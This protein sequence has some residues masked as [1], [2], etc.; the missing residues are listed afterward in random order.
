MDYITASSRKKLRRGL[1]MYSNTGVA[2]ITAPKQLKTALETVSWDIRADGF[3]AF[4]WQQI[5]KKDFR[6]QPE[7]FAKNNYWLASPPPLIPL[8]KRGPCLAAD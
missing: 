5:E 7:V 3:F 2:E 6:S 8:L 1:K 4:S